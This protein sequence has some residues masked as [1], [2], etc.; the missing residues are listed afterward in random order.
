M[1]LTSLVVSLTVSQVGT[2]Q[3]ELVVVPDSSGTAHT[4]NNLLAG[5]GST[6][7]AFGAK[8]GSTVKPDVFDA[9][10]VFTTNPLPNNQLSGDA[11]P[12]GTIVRATSTGA[13]YGSP[14]IVLQPSEFGSP[15]K[16]S[17]CVYM[18]PVQNLPM[19]PDDDFLQPMFGGGTMKSGVTGIEVVGHEFG[20]QWMVQSAFDQGSGLDVLH[21]AQR[22]ALLARGLRARHRAEHHR[23]G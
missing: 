22:A 12:K 4:T 23:G 3:G 13:L 11:T 17:H 21:R 18:V 2:V 20:H 8:G 6:L 1:L 10:V 5:L 19:N 7:C 14:L 16:L 9:V 15:A